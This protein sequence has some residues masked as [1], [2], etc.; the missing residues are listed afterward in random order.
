MPLQRADL[1]RNHGVEAEF[2]K[3]G[4]TSLPTRHLGHRG[5]FEARLLAHWLGYNLGCCSN[6]FSLGLSVP[7]TWSFYTL[8]F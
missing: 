1:V 2:G 7:L 5:S 8:N 3:V 4:P 6:T